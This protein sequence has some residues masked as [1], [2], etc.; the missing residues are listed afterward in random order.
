VRE[1]HGYAKR[2]EKSVHT[3]VEHD[4]EKKWKKKKKKKK[5]SHA[6]SQI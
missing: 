4:D 1:R 5:N 6:L 3:S 2:K